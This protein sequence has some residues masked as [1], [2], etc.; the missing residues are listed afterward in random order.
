MKYKTKHE[1]S[2]SEYESDSETTYRPE[3]E[4]GKGSYAVT[5]LFVANNNKKIA[6]ISPNPERDEFSVS[7]LDAK[8]Q[9]FKTHYPNDK[10]EMFRPGDGEYRLRVPFIEGKTY[11]HA[12]CKYR[13]TSLPTA[14]IVRIFRS[15]LHELE[16][17]HKN[18]LAFIDLKEDNIMYNVKTGKSHLIDGGL[19]TKIG[20]LLRPSIFQGKL[21][22]RAEQIRR[23]RAPI[24]P[25]CLQSGAVVIDASMDVYGI[26]FFIKQIA[27]TEESDLAKLA[28]SCLDINPQN[29]KKLDD[30]ISFFLEKAR[31]TLDVD[32]QKKYALLGCMIKKLQGIHK[33]GRALVFLSLETVHV[34]LHYE[35]PKMKSPFIDWQIG[36]KVT[37]AFKS[38]FE[39][40][41]E[42]VREEY[43]Q[44]APECWSKSGKTATEAM[45]VY[46]LGSMF[47]YLFLTNCKDKLMT[48]L[49]N[50]CMD[51]NP[52]TRPDIP[53]LK[54]RLDLIEASLGNEPSDRS[55]KTDH[56]YH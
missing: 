24:A 56:C 46:S 12:F 33:S 54:K 3:K 1:D 9:F 18:G 7:E 17:C 47:S 16:Q 26:G 31:S 34:L 27:K 52:M 6:I 14:F 23:E 50:D 35:D 55:S 49:I 41:L 51:P 4:L 8:Y 22:D 25:E 19:S 38:P 28:D 39:Q 11:S 20:T 43:T 45:D 21:I 53:T 44:F 40:A 2:L 15:A 36:S 48:D 5:R 13:R 42:E 30:V 10:V 29:R 32:L 37:F